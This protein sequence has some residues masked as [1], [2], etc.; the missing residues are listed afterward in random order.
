[1]IMISKGFTN[2]KKTGYLRETQMKCELY[3]YKKA[4]FLSRRAALSRLNGILFW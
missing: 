2:K 3:H 4:G 1:M